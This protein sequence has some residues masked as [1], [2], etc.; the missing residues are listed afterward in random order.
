MTTEQ[1][2]QERQRLVRAV[3]RLEMN[4]D[5]QLLRKKLFAMAPPL[6][7]TAFSTVDKF[8]PHA[9]AHR[10]GACSI[11]RYLLTLALSSLGQEEEPRPLSSMAA[12]VGA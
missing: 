11:T 3:R 12:Y 1:H 7:G 6:V 10:D 8:N 9:A 4:E 2:D 5:Y